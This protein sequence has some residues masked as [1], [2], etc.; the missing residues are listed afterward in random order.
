VLLTDALHSTL[1]GAPSGL[2]D[3][4]LDI[5]GFWQPGASQ[6]QEDIIVFVAAKFEMFL[7]LYVEK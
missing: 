2:V 1:T 6:D 7:A 5:K 3:A 4:P